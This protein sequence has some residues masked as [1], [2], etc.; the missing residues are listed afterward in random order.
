MT[1]QPTSTASTDP[2][3]GSITGC[4]ALSWLLVSFVHA[5][6][7]TIGWH[8]KTHVGHDNAD[9]PWFNLY[10]ES[11]RGE[12]DHFCFIGAGRRD[13]RLSSFS[14]HFVRT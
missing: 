10:S 5:S 4:R 2:A 13:D 12:G 9:K 3:S 14:P 6:V 11:G 7:S 1:E 8:R